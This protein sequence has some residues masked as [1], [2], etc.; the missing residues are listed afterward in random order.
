M[1][2]ECSACS[3]CQICGPEDQNEIKSPSIEYPNG[4]NEI[5]EIKE[6]KEN[7]IKNPE[8]KSNLF[9]YYNKNIPTIIF[10]Q[11]K[12]KKFLNKLKSDPKNRFYNKNYGTYELSNDNLDIISEK[13]EYNKG[14]DTFIKKIENNHKLKSSSENFKLLRQK[15]STINKNKNDL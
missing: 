12:I 6:I 5:E 13:N 7:T 4:K 9:E 2:L 10:L 15:Y 3:K 1:G 11:L 8:S 14:A